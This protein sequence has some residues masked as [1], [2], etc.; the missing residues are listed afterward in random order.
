MADCTNYMDKIIEF[1]KNSYRSDRTAF[2]FE[3][4]SFIIIVGSSLTLAIN[5]DNPNM[6]LVYPLFFIGS[7]TQLYAAK[8]R[9]SAWVMLLNSYFCIINTFGFSVAAGWL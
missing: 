2:K 4:V 8:R 9:G 3:L 1:W 5:A 6:V 7:V